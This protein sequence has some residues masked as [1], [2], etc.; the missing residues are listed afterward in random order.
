M[1]RNGEQHP[2]FSLFVLT[3]EQQGSNMDYSFTRYLLSKQTVDDRALNKDVVK[4]LRI[5]MPPGPVFVIEVGAG[6]GT[7]LKR[8]IEWNILCVGDYVLVDEL[9]ENIA[10]A[11]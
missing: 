10:Y 4:T 1:E 11:R 8:L 7:M 9:S 5:N 2:Q 3:L 6:I